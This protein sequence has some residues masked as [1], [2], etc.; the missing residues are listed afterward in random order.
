MN[1]VFSDPESVF[2]NYKL[3]VGQNI[4]VTGTWRE[5]I[6]S[7]S[8]E[9]HYAHSDPS[10]RLEV[11]GNVPDSYPLQK[12]SQTLLFLRSLPTLR[13]R[14]ATLSSVVRLRSQL[15][16]LLVNFFAEN[17]FFKVNPPLV[18][19]ADCEGAG[20][21]FAVELTRRDLFFGK[22]AYLSVSGQLHLEPLAQSLSRVW[23]LSPCFRAEESHTTRHLSEFWMLEVEVS[24]VTEVAQ[25]TALAEAMIKESTRSLK[26]YLDDLV[27]SRFSKE[28]Q[29]KITQRWESLVDDENWP[30]ITYSEAIEIIN[31]VKNKGRSKGRLEWGD[32]ILTD[33]EKWLAGDHFGKPV[34][35]T[36]YPESQKPFY[37]PRSEGC[38]PEEPTVACFDLVFPEI[39][40]LIGGSLREHDHERLLAEI[41]RRNMDELALAWYLSTRENGAS[42]H[43]GFGMGFE[44]LV[45]YL[46]GMDNVRDVTPYPRAPDLCEC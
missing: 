11:V 23:C 14:T 9:L 33:H 20:D 3:K 43:G 32:L 15:E 30:L 8:H 27:A 46:G 7:Q 41:R 29:H 26:P 38:D 13:H 2:E 40:E 16:T 34:F 39:G 25:L 42:P 21:Q 37:M 17:G 35:I 12:K 5:S 1:M 36:D 10:N 45:A 44:R 19:A 28:D 31:R 18:T 24:Y 4:C 22:K 6:G